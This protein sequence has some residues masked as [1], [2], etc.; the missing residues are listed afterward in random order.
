MKRT[1]S[2]VLAVAALVILLASAAFAGEAE[3]SEIQRPV[4]ASTLYLP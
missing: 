2:A 4:D 3:L 1:F